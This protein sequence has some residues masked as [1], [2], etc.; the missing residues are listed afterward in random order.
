M[1]DD[2]YMHSGRAH[3]LGGNM[4]TE[5][6]WV[7]HARVSRVIWEE[8]GNGDS[9]RVFQG[10][11][12]WARGSILIATASLSSRRAWWLYARGRVSAILPLSDPL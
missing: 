6:I 1:G 4:L 5:L 10:V 12:V 7:S 9:S 11:L 3:S 2:P 8:E